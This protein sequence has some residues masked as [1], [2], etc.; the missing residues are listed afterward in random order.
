MDEGDVTVD[1]GLNEELAAT[2]YAVLL[3][4]T[5]DANAAVETA[6]VELDGNASSLN[7]RVGAGW[8]KEGWDAGRMSHNTLAERALW[9]ELETDAALEICGLEELVPGGNMS[10]P[11]TPPLGTTYPPR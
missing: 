9:H 8:C 5:R 10:D 7:K 11:S 3:A 2:D 6:V 1:A 4:V